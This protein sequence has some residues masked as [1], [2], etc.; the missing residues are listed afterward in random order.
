MEG[1]SCTCVTYSRVELLEEAIESFLRQ[2]YTGPKELVILNDTDDQTLEFEHPEIVIIN[3]KRRFRSLGEKRDAAVS[4]CKYD[5]IAVWDDD[6]IFLPHRLSFSMNKIIENNL[7][8]YKLG[9][10]FTWDAKN[11]IT[12]WF[13][14]S[15][16]SACIFSRDAYIST[17]GHGYTNT[18][19]DFFL[20]NQIKANF[21]NSCL[22]EKYG[23]SKN[24]QPQD[25][26]YFYRWS[27]IEGHATSC[28]GQADELNWIS[29][30]R[31]N[32][33]K[34]KTGLIQLKPVWRHDYLKLSQDFIKSL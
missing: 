33:Q 11:G 32:N 10:S 26:Y 29:K 4:L 24:I 16:F 23:H 19:E 8:Y 18:G 2:D 9:S 6:D 30:R 34:R 3:S 12:K 13:N 25:I 21:K 7:E 20:E 31:K 28:K 17:S 15:Y 27:D 22:T 14:N 5:W 1:I